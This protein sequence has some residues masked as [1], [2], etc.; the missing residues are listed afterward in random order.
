MHSG[1]SIV[2]G[3]RDI[4]TCIFADTDCRL[5]HCGLSAFHSGK[6]IQDASATI[7]DAP[8]TLILGH[9]YDLVLSIFA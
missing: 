3:G 7:V 8:M 6:I 9:G 4:V 2:G 5:V 1:H